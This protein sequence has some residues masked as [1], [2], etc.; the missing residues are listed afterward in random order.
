MLALTRT[1]GLQS[2][3]EGIE[4]DAQREALAHEGCDLGQGF[5]FSASVDPQAAG[6]M[7]TIDGAPEETLTA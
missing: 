3:A 5:L 7:L 6:R 2:L 4:T 1:L